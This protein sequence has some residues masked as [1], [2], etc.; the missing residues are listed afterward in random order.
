MLHKEMLPGATDI[1]SSKILIVDDSDLN[2]QII[3]NFFRNSGYNDLLT[4]SN[5]K[6]ALELVHIYKPDLLIID[7]VMPV[8]DGITV[9]QNL[10][11]KKE[12]ELIPIIV[13][14]GISE[15]EQQVAAWKAG[16]NDIINKPINFIELLTRTKNL[17]KQSFFVKSLD[18]YK[19]VMLADLKQASELQLS[20]VPNDLQQQKI[21][22]NFGVNINSIFYPSR[23]LSGDLWG[24]VDFKTPYKIGIWLCDFAGKGIRAA[25]QTFK[26]HTLITNKNASELHNQPNHFLTY[27][28]EQLC[29][30]KHSQLFAT[31]IY[32]IIDYKNK[33]FQY[34]SAGA[35]SPII[36]NAKNKFHTCESDGIPL[37]IDKK[38]KY[39]LK[40]IPID[41]DTNLLFYS[42]VLIEDKSLGEKNLSPKNFEKIIEQI[43]DKD[44]IKFFAELCKNKNLSDDLT[45][46]QINKD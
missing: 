37:G 24:I 11:N 19:K 3:S 29:A 36:F 30:E 38:S 34:A 14:T 8:M 44:F 28:N 45:L 42:D 12:F 4:A 33:T 17:L 13:Q 43:N 10:R 18:A 31:F 20:L 26:I 7:L 39:D 41:N 40:N 46:I 22:K 35:T 21:H 23:F 1:E 32:G 16:A 15:A 6:Q 2:L 5:G 27:L 9:I 25:L